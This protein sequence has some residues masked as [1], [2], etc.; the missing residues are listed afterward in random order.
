MKRPPVAIVDDAPG[1][2]ASL[3]IP[4]SRSFASERPSRPRVMKMLSGFTSRWMIPNFVRVI[5]RVEQIDSDVERLLDRQASFSLEHGSQRL[6]LESLHHVIRKTQPVLRRPGRVHL[7]D[8]RMLE[9]GER[10]SLTREPRRE[11]G[12]L[13]EVAV[14]RLQHVALADRRVLDVV[15]GTHPARAEH[16]VHAINRAGNRLT[17]LIIRCPLR[18]RDE[19]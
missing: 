3:M 13:G 10:A 12:A 8:V 9:L 6:P 1:A 18:H 4:K 11:I 17:R 2:V 7:D 14:E 19:R 16:A 15:D 5:E